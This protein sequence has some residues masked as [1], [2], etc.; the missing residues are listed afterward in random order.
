[1]RHRQFGLSLGGLLFGSIVLILVAL[2][3]FKLVPEY[4]DYFTAVKAINAIAQENPGATPAEVRKSFDARQAID[5]IPQLKPSDLDITSEGGQTVI[6]FA[7]R[8]D[9]PL[10]ANVGIYIDF[11]ATTRGR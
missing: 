10:F 7:Y 8:K 5:N 4:L 3:G 9:I 2:V 11:Q 1:M 6:G